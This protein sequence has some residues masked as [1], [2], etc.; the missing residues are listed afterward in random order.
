M[1]APQLIIAMLFAADALLAA[2]FHG[3]RHCGH[4]DFPSAVAI[5]GVEIAVLWWGGFWG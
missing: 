4:Y 1:T 5:S 2:H 3:K